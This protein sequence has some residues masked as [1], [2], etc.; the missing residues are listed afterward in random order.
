MKKRIISALLATTM[1]MALAGCNSKEDTS[2]KVGS[3]AEKG[4]NSSSAG[5]DWPKKT[6]NIICPFG[7]GGDSDYNARIFADQ[8]T[9][10]LDETFIVTN[11]SGN[12]GATGVEEAYSA[13]P[14]GYTILF[15]QDAIHVNEVTGA[16]DYGLDGFDLSCIVAK[17]PGSIVCV[18][19]KSKYKTLDDL[20]EASKK[21]NVTFAAN[22]GAT[23]HVMGAMLNEA[24]AEFNLVDMGG[25]ADRIPA[26]MG[27]QCDAIANALGSAGQYLES[28]DFRA[29]ALL[30]D[31]RNENY[32]DIP[33][34][35]ELGYNASFPMYYFFAFPK[36]TDSE[37]VEK[38]ADA[39]EEI[40]NME[41][42]QKAQFD[43]YAQS[44]FFAKG[45]E[46]ETIE[47][48]QLKTVEALKDVLE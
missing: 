41:E 20:V 7:A 38:L 5:T 28:G 23:T 33:T 37:I 1:V 15:D 43:S 13:D 6:V 24:G 9:K 44:P 34:A 27:G 39:C 17:S 4:S 10:K 16:I 31:E 18:S 21:D 42:V 11:V 32:P 30:E 25:A 36:G 19:S 26:L 12:G 35:K 40:A 2:S 3:S 22:A 46:A 47:S 48:D 29:L 14:D 45:E 8:L